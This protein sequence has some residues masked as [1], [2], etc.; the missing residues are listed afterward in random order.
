MFWTPK[1]RAVLSTII[2]FS[3]SSQPLFAQALAQPSLARAT[4]TRTLIKREQ[5]E[6]IY[7]RLVEV[8]WTPRTGLFRSFPDSVDLKLSQ[9]SATY[10]QAAMGLLAIRF[11]DLERARSLSLFFRNAWDASPTQRGRRAGTHGL[12]NFYNAEFGTEGIEKTVH[13]G[14]NAWVGL[15]AAK[16]ANVTRDPE[17]LRLALDIEYWMANVLPHE[18]GGIAMGVSDDPYGASWSRIYST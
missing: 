1:I 11:G 9:Q 7:R 18:K 4:V 6:A 17:A 15:F 3:L 12:A 8:H 2:A 10:E 16:L 13:T 14:P 5:A